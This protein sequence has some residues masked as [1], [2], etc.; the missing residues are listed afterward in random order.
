M[1]NFADIYAFLNDREQEIN[2][3]ILLCKSSKVRETVLIKSSI[4]LLAYNTV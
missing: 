2:A 1:N 4:V 3:M